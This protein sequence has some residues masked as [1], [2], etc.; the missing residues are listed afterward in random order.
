MTEKHRVT[1]PKFIEFETK[2]YVDEEQLFSFKLAVEKFPN[3][4]EFLYVE[5]THKYYLGEGESFIRHRMPA[6]RGVKSEVTV[7]VKPQGAKNNIVRSEF[8][9][10]IAGTSEAEISEALL[11]LGYK[12]NFAIWKACHIYRFN[13]A[14]LVFYTVIDTTDGAKKRRD[15]FVEIEVSEENISSL[16]EAEAFVIIAKYEGLL[17]D[18][19]IKPNRRVRKSLFESYRR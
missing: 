9:W 3:L 5:G 1:M 15:S 7:K 13:D 18:M 11:A 14:T 10:Q 4:N 12:F 2:Y 19:N 16:T 6:F 17:A 8:N